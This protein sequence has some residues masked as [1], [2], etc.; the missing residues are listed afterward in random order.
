MASRTFINRVFRKSGPPIHLVWFITGRCNLKCQHCFYDTSAN[1]KKDEFSL[2]EI[3]KTI[4]NLPPLLSILL[5]GGEP[6]LRRDLLEVVKLLAKKGSISNISITT[7]GF[8]TENILKTVEKI[9]NAASNVNIFLGVSIDGYE[10]EHDKYRMRKGSYKNAILTIKGLKRLESNYSNLRLGIGTTLHSGN[11]HIMINLRKDLYRQFG[12]YPSITLIRGSIKSPVLKNIDAAK[13]KE[14]LRDVEKERRKSRPR[15]PLESIVNTR[16]WIGE[17][18]AYETFINQSR[19]YSCYAGSLMGVIY[20]NGDVYP[21]EMLPRHKL[22]NLREDDYDINKVW[23]STRVKDI[24]RWIQKK[25]CFC[26]YECQ[27]TCN[28][29]YN[30]RF[31]PIF[32]F[33]ILRDMIRKR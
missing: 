4:N 9:L 8:D 7:N 15:I 33:N 5:T 29:S 25:E 21:C 10:A 6:F 19:S 30:V 23:T 20:E 12:I 3:S 26:T 32:M 28:T 13:Y 11:Q 2:E 22:G 16:G 31:A 24:G 1:P 18:L 14:V 17:K 27:Y